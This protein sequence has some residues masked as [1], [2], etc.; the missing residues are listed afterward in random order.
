MPILTTKELQALNDQLDF[1]RVLHCKYLAAVQESTDQELKTM[2]Q[3]C[4][5]QHL[6]NYN[7]LLGSAALRRRTNERSGTYD[8]FSVQ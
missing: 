1:E 8:R 2:F 4:A 5:S 3:N 7:T 6:Q